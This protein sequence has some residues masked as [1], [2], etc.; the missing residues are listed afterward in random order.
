MVALPPAILSR[1]L[2]NVTNDLGPTVKETTPSRVW[3][4]SET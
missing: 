2:S 4:P 3:P 1:L